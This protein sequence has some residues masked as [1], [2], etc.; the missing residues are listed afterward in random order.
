MEQEQES[1]RDTWGPD[2]LSLGDRT[3][4]DTLNTLIDD[5]AALTA[6]V[7]E[8]QSEIATLRRAG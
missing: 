7:A 6:R 2:V 8:L 1:L 3:I 5:V 4:N